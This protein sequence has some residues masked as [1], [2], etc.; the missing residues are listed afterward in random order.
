[1]PI[2]IQRY[3]GS[4]PGFGRSWDEF[5]TGWVDTTP[6]DGA[7]WLGNEILYQLTKRKIYTI[8]F[9]LQAS[10]NK[11]FWAKYFNFSVDDENSNY[12]VNTT[13]FSGDL[14][15]P[16]TGGPAGITSGVMF[17]DSRQR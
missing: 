5:K 2:M 8:R 16:N 3:D 14:H 7:Y 12:A 11:Q 15:D 9:F 13:I 6:D 1:M 10:N 17:T 4:E